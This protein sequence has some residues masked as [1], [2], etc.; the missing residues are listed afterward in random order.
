MRHERSDVVSDTERRQHQQNDPACLDLKDRNA[1]REEAVAGR[2]KQ[3]RGICYC[4]SGERVDERMKG[5]EPTLTRKGG[6]AAK[7]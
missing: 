2:T 4:V 3:Q 6:R 1:L 5:V 7:I